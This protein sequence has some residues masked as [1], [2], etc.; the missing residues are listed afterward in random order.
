MHINSSPSCDFRIDFG[1]L[2]QFERQDALEEAVKGDVV[3]RCDVLNPRNGSVHVINA[4]A[5]GLFL[6]LVIC[7]IDAESF[8][9]LR[10]EFQVGAC[11]P[12]Q[13]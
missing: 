3:A 8:P 6:M 5:P 13:Y 2:R 1:N 12:V 10:V 7:R 9:A 4:E 11:N